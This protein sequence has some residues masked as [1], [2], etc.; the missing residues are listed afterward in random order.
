MS[1]LTFEYRALQPDGAETRGVATGASKADAYRQLVSRGLTPVRLHPVTPG[2]AE[3]RG[4]GARIPLHDLAHFTYQFGVLMAANLGVAEGLR[5]IAEQ[6][7]PGPLRR[8]IEDLV[9]RVQAGETIAAAMDAHR[10]VLGDVY[11][12]AI[13][14]AEKAGTLP[15]VL[16]HLSEM[17][18]RTLES[19]RQVKGAMMYPACVTA[20]LVLASGFLVAFVIPK[21][22]SM[23]AKRGAELPALTKALMLLGE[24]LQSFWWVYLGMIAAVALATRSALARPEGRLF[25]DHL[26]HRVPYLRQILLGLA[27]SR[28]ARILG[29]GVSSGLTLIECVDLAGKASKPLGWPATYAAAA[30]SPAPRSRVII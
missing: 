8:M 11:V 27:I 28:F 3:V 10:A 25:L 1:T 24:S 12:E 22:A 5:G 17:L 16:E 14:A 29:I 2:R 13:R 7:K 30:L 9:T 4:S 6:E 18:E 20:V 19:Q 15:T 21:F 23:F 26:A